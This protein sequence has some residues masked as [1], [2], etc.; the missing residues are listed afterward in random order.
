MDTEV[1]ETPAL[2]PQARSDNF[3]SV[4]RIGNKCATALT[5]VVAADPE[6]IV[7]TIKKVMPELLQEVVAV[8]FEKAK[9]WPVIEKDKDLQWFRDLD[10]DSWV[11]PGD[12]N[13]SE[14]YKAKVLISLS[15]EISHYPK[16]QN[17]V[18]KSSKTW[19]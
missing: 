18:V 10:Y 4:T 2:I 13:E 8:T 11:N 14:F 5:K 19:F 15:C 16:S 17:V 6:T 9:L 1:P 7:A 3:N 12:L